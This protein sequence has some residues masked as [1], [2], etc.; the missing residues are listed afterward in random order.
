MLVVIVK[1]FHGLHL[2]HYVPLW[3]LMFGCAVAA[4]VIAV[5]FH[6]LV[7]KPLLTA[8]NR[9]RGKSGAGREAGPAS[10]RGTTRPGPVLASED[11]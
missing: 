9:A 2:E 10:M 6:V 8:L 5:V 7:E 11:A 3:V 1:L 4:T